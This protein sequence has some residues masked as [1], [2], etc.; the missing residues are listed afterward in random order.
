MSHSIT[1][2]ET[3]PS[4]HAYK[5]IERIGQKA[6]VWEI[7]RRRSDRAARMAYNTDKQTDSYGDE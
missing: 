7:W 4:P 3:L 2:V 1:I 5:G 6:V